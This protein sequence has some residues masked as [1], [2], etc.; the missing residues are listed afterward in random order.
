[1]FDQTPRF[2][3]DALR[4]GALRYEDVRNEIQDGDVLLFD[5]TH[6]LSSVVKR[7]TSGAYSHCG[8]VLT[9]NGRRMFVHADVANGVQAGLLSAALE[10]FRGPGVSWLSVAAEAREQLDLEALTAEAQSHLGMPYDVWG[11]VHAGAHVLL[12]ARAPRPADEPQPTHCSAFVARCFRKAGVPLL[13]RAD[14]LVSPDDI[15]RSPAFVDRGVIQLAG[16]SRLPQK[17]RPLGGA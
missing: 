9:W 1:M 16:R 8:I 2:R 13:A 7:L 11:V 10:R 15:S 5:G 12:G 6:F 4:S 14:K 3:P 17:K